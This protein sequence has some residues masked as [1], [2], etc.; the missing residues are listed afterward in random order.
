MGQPV[1]E[2]VPVLVM[3]CPVPVLA[4]CAF[5]Y[6]HIYL[7]LDSYQLTIIDRNGGVGCKGN[8]RVVEKSSPRVANM[9]REG[10]SDC[11]SNL[12]EGVD[13]WCWGGVGVSVELPCLCEFPI[14][15]GKFEDAFV[16]ILFS[17]A[18]RHG[19]YSGVLSEGVEASILAASTYKLRMDETPMRAGRD[20]SPAN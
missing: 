2:L 6:Q 15:V 9:N 3:R 11:E 8:S 20:Q 16:C 14:M 12:L 5:G 4:I 1:P 19:A 17:I 10:V 18:Y 7:G 13:C